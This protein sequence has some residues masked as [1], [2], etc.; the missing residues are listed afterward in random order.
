MFPVISIDAKNSVKTKEKD[1]G[2]YIY[3]RL[4]MATDRNIITK[5]TTLLIHTLRKHY[6]D[7]FHLRIR[8]S[9]EGNIYLAYT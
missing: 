2:K 1:F 7:L 8:Y 3:K 9:A 6:K 4:R 5:C